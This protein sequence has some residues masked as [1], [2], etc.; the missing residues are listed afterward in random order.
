[1]NKDFP[2]IVETY[3]EAFDGI[4]CRVLVTAEDEET[5]RAAAEDATATPA[6]VIGR[7]EGGVESW[8]DK[9]QTP[10][11][12]QGVILQFWGESGGGME[13][14]LEKF[15]KELS[16]RI[17]QDILVKPFTSVF[18]ANQDY[19]G[20]LDMMDRVGHCGDGYEWVEERYDREMIIVPTMVPDF[21]I[22]RYLGYSKGVAGGN[23]WYFCE[24]KEA[25][26]KAGK[27][28]LKV[29]LE[30]EGAVAPFDIVSA[31]S[32][33]ETDYPEIGP[34]TNHLY[35]P[36]LKGKL[37]GDSRVPEGVGYIP[38]IVIN[39]RTLEECKEAM[40]NGIESVRG[41][42]GVKKISAGNYGGELGE[43]KIHLSELVE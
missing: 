11:G 32:K 18:N 38:E 36:S 22:E 43:Y 26:M 2:K 30:V 4:Y 41:V 39:A 16:Y 25:V 24:T 13:E 37:G 1:M 27:K 34:T 10:D 40:K 5:L 14:V 21:E 12:R 9:E 6:T 35:C 31:G 8:L 7:T 19:D 23:F 29:I 33:P 20:K 28:A 3:A 42:D 15:E 17:R